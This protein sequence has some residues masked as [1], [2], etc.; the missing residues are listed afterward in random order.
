MTDSE[1]IKAFLAKE[2]NQRRNGGDLDYIAEARSAY[3]AFSRL[4]ARLEELERA[5]R[6][7]QVEALDRVWPGNG[8]DA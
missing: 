7:K 3:N 8:L 2:L 6:V 4:N 1:A 5:E